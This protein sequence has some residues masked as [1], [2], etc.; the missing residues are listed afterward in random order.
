MYNITLLP[1]LFATFFKI[2][3][4]TLADS[5]LQGRIFSRETIKRRGREDTAPVKHLTHKVNKH[6]I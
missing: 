2:F 3:F 4:N 5:V 1:N 6:I